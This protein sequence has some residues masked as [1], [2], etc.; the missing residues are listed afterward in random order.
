LDK[1][2]DQPTSQLASDQPSDGDHHINFVPFRLFPT[3]PTNNSTTSIPS[4]PYLTQKH[5]VDNMCKASSCQV[6]KSDGSM[7]IFQARDK[8]IESIIKT[9]LCS[10]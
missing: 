7:L 6:I 2:N 3:T 10:S 8:D 9:F 1:P 5:T 4:A